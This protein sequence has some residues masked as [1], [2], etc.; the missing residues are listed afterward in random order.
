MHS[1]P[2]KT[3]SR[4]HKPH[5]LAFIQNPLKFTHNC[6]TLSRNTRIH[7]KLYV[8]RKA[9]KCLKNFLMFPENP[10]IFTQNALA[11]TE[12]A[13][14]FSQTAVTS[15]PNVITLVQNPVTFAHNTLARSHTMSSHSHKTKCSRIRTKH[16]HIHATL[17]HKM[18]LLSHEPT[19]IVLSHRARSHSDKTL[20][21]VQ[22]HLTFFEWKPELCHS[23]LRWGMD[24]APACSTTTWF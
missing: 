1:H 9:L 11:F 22:K 21:H 8:Q 5:T 13:L 2:N 18:L 7:T 16:S 19:H 10:F 20:S 14:A 6:Y 12:N 4:H 24:I 3:C 23:A 17:S 15:T